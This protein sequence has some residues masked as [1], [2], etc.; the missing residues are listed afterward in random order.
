MWPRVSQEEAKF[1]QFIKSKKNQIFKISSS[2][3]L[4]VVLSNKNAPLF[5]HVIT[6]KGLSA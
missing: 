6:R 3:V 5:Q 1:K 2:S 4:D